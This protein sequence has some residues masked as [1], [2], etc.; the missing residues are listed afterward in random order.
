[1]REF[2]IDF[3]SAV[4]Q[5][6]R[7]IKKFQI[8]TVVYK[9]VFR[10]KGL[11]YEGYRN[12][13]PD[14]DA[15]M[16]DWKASLRADKLLAKQYAEERNL[17][18]YF[19]VDASNSMLFGTGGK[20]KAEFSAQIVAALSH[21]II[22]S[23]DN[24]GLIMFS[25]KIIKYLP[26]SKGKNQFALFVKYLSDPGLYGSG[27]SLSNVLNFAL[28]QIKSR[29]SAVIL[30]SD[31]IHVRPELSRQFKLLGTKFE[32]FALM[33]RDPLDDNLPE[34]N[35][36]LVIQHPYSDK[37][38]TVDPRVAAEKYRENALQQKSFVKNMFKQANI[39]IVELNTSQD[40]VMPLVSFLRKRARGV[41]E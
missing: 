13:E 5:F 35:K 29:A 24:I 20:T 1:M 33:I 31:F 26:P 36:M 10:G 23:D 22:N 18:I 40:F 19:L 27:L 2:N 21:L 6:E 41:L 14:D 12:V 17:D 39:D 32:T 3:A 25:D 11:E 8:R 28:N 7:I 4:S 34:I 15:M 9:T 37:Q 30:I 38:I 16:I